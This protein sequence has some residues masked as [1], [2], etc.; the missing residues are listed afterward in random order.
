MVTPQEQFATK[1]K[2]IEYRLEMINQRKRVHFGSF[3]RIKRYN[4]II[5]SLVNVL[6]TV[7]VTSIAI[8]FSGHQFTLVIGA[9]SNSLSAIISAAL[10][11]IGLDEKTY[12]HQTSYLQ[13]HDLYEKLISDLLVE[14][15]NN[16]VLDTILKEMNSHLGIILDSCEPISIP[17]KMEDMS[18][19][20]ISSANVSQ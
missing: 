8:T 20:Q 19:I 3:K 12:S 6:N 1:L 16:E 5:K 14:N 2:L 7:S 4:M 18:G 13:F 11:A 15:L 10:S 9:V 17:H